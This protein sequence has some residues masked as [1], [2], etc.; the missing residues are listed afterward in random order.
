MKPNLVHS[1]LKKM[2]K[3]IQKDE[4]TKQKLTLEPRPTHNNISLKTIYTY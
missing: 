2:S 1:A 3:V 4:S